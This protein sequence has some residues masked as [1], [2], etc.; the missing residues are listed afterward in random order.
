MLANIP[1]KTM[2]LIG[3]LKN[4]VLTNGVLANASNMDILPDGYPAYSLDELCAYMV[5]HTQLYNHDYGVN[6][7]Y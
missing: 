3:R 6:M 5:F 7:N 2:S 1:R 4:V